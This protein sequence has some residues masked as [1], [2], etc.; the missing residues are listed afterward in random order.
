MADEG[1]LCFS[2]S[3]SALC[4]TKKGTNQLIFKGAPQGQETIVT[5]AWDSTGRDLD[6]FAYWDGAPD[7]TAGYA[8]GSGGTSGAYSL[9][10]S[11][12][13]TSDN[14]SEWCKIK[15]SPWGAGQNT[16]TVHFNFFG[17]DEDHPASSCV[18]IA[19]QTGG[20]TKIKYN[21]SC[22]TS[23]GRA[24][25]ES[26]PSCTVTFDSNGNLVSLT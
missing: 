21:Q 8:H 2:K 7:M 17:S 26:D 20:P 25:N 4:Y 14:A 16:F 5:F 13:I 1:K 15:M 3:G 18:V 24:A 10:Y 23:H 9:I 22:S 6:I 19:S 12:D 11:G